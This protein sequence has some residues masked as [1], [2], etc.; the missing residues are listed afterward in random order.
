M[1][2]Q[3]EQLMLAFGPATVVSAMATILEKWDWALQRDD[4]D[5]G[6]SAARDVAK[7]RLKTDSR[8]VR[9][10]ADSMELW[11]CTAITDIPGRKLLAK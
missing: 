7:R 2:K 3:L 4:T 8:V 9:L 5:Y 6:N 11:D 10:A 1:E